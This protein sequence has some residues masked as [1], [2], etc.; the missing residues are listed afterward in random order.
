MD[1][2][3]T[4]SINLGIVVVTLAVILAGAAWEML[5]NNEW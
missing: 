3:L 5:K 1:K 2:T 4:H